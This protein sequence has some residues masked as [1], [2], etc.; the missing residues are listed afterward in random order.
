MGGSGWLD[1]LKGRE[2]SDELYNELLCCK[3]RRPHGW[4]KSDWR[5]AIEV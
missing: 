4:P 5:K 2:M 1:R 3:G